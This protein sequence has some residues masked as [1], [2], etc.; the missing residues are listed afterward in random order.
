MQD[1]LGKVGSS[2]YWAGMAIAV[3]LCILIGCTEPLPDGLPG[4]IADRDACSV[5]HGSPDN[6]APPV[7]VSGLTSTA[8]IEVGAHQIHLT[9]GSIRAALPCESCHTVPLTV[10]QQGHRDASPAEITWSGLA[11][12]G[13]LSPVWTRSNPTCSNI[14]CHGATLSGGSLK[15][16]VWTTVD[17]TQTGCGTCHGNPPPSPHTTESQCYTCHSGTVTATGGIDITGNRHIDGVVQSSENPHPAGW[18]GSTVHGYAF[19]DTPEDC[20]A[21]HGI[22]LDGGTSGLS[23]DECHTGGDAWRTDCRFCHGGLDNATGAPP[24]GLRG[25]TATSSQVVGAHTVHLTESPSHAA[26]A[27]NTCHTVPVS[28][29]DPGHIDSGTDVEINF[30]TPAGSTAAYTRTT[31]TCSSLYCH[32]NGRTV[33][34]PVSWTS[35]TALTCRSCHGDAGS[36]GS[37]SGEHDEHLSE[38][39]ACAACHKTVINSANVII[40]KTAHVNGSVDVSLTSGTYNSA[41]RSCSDTGCHGTESW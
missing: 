37:L 25:E 33:S 31:A 30:S 15:N 14:Y 41:S 7:S 22:N 38:G 28:W 19:Y 40:D 2:R 34:G 21:C 4:D 39:V 3:I 32:G 27:C 17:G 5:C 10:D 16:P 6:A 11:A 23:C 24:Y 12:T 20:R 26:W 29:N 36:S 13:G 9:G 18:D 1:K 8:D 35:P